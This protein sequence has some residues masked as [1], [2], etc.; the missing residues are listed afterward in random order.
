HTNTVD[1]RLKRIAQL[2]HL[3]PT[4]PSGLWYLRSAPIARTYT[5]T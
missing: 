3:D 5:T 4:Q 2:T 1:Y